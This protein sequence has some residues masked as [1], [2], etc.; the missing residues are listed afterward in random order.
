MPIGWI[1]GGASILGSVLG[2]NAAESA[3]QTQANAANQASQ[4][5][6]Q[7]FDKTQK[8]LAPYMQYGINS[9]AELQ[10]AEGLR[11]GPTT[12]GRGGIPNGY[13]TQPFTFADYKKSPGYNFQMTQ[14]INAIDNSA[15]A[16]GGIGGGNTLKA[17]D[18]FGQGLANT[19][20]QQAFNNY[21]QQQQQLYSFL[22]GGVGTGA[23]AA[24]GLGGFG[25]Q[26]GANIGSNLIGAG[27]A[28]AAGQV[29][30]ANAATGGLN[31]LT[32]LAF[33]S[34]FNPSA[35]GGGGGNPVTGTNVSN[36]F[37]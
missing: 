14:G 12:P 34:Q 15:A 2:G 3:A 37:G 24:A 9:L 16:R 29:G 28:Q 33:L 31:S 20:Y 26:T 32:Q 4:V 13:L 21:T 22:S 35:F 23:N 10:R 11:P 5:E 30:A 27:N 36:T 17:L 6:L 19:D 8:N 1:L 25:A 18:Q 7:M